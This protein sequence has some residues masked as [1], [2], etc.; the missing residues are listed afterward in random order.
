MI[1]KCW[2]ARGSIPV[3][4]EKFVKYGGDTACIEIRTKSDDIIIIDA[5]TGI[6]RL[7]NRVV[8]E[9]RFQ[10]H[11]IFTHA[12]WD[13]IMGFPFF[14]P[15]Y[16]ENAELRMYRCPF[17][18]NFVETALSRV[19]AAPFFPVKFGELKASIVY[20]EACPDVF[21]IGSVR[22]VPISLSHP[23]GGS[24]YKFIEDGKSFVYLTDNE[25]GF[26]HPGGRS[27]DAYL[28]FSSGA[29]FLI[30]DA[31]YTPEEYRATKSWGHSV[32]T[33]AIELAMGAGVKKVGLFHLNQDRTD[34]AMD[35]IAETCRE[36]IM[37][38]GHKIECIAVGSDMTF[39]L[40]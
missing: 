6:R 30:H 34:K 1:I 2:G 13:H 15:V 10:Y 20:E 32:Y 40:A 12:H 33:D 28:E 8:K 36:Q 38:N 26:V 7:G 31:E 37:T 3:S 21:E 19:M 39:F 23:N 16:M 11:M 9:N 29:D 14:R 5:G 24:G 27:F 22:I 35:Q 17:A 4:G 25:L 18:S